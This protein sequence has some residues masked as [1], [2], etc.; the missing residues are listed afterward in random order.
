MSTIRYV[1]DNNVLLAKWNYNRFGYESV[2]IR[3]RNWQYSYPRKVSGTLGINSLWGPRPPLAVFN[4]RSFII[5]SFKKISSK[6]ISSKKISSKKISS[7]KFFANKKISNILNFRVPCFYSYRIIHFM[8]VH[9]L[10]L[11]TKNKIYKFFFSFLFN[12]I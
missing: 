6:K 12:F 11:W 9:L 1:N 4:S 2:T 10:S 8:L 7:K 3:R 5:H